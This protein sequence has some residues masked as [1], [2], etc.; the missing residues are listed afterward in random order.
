MNKILGKKVICITIDHLVLNRDKYKR[1][2]ISPDY[3]TD[4]VESLTKVLKK[5]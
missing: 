5:Q 2:N 4:S 3:Y 1:L